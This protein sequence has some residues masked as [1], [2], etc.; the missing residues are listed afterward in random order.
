LDQGLIVVDGMPHRDE[1]EFPDIEQRAA[2]AHRRKS[3]CEWIPH[4]IEEAQVDLRPSL[5]VENDSRIELARFS[6][7][8]FEDVAVAEVPPVAAAWG[9]AMGRV[10]TR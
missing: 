1:M 7:D 5:G 9:V 8:S 10:G 2:E 4:A 6:L 3:G